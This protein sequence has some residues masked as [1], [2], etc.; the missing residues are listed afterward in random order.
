[1]S[2]SKQ[3]PLPQGGSLTDMAVSGTTV[4]EDAAKP[5]NLPS[6]AQPGQGDDNVNQGM[7][8][9]DLA[10]AAD[11]AGDIARVSFRAFLLL[12]TSFSG[13]ILLLCSFFFL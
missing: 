1:M 6:V 10:D 4:P 11:N 3:D 13:P 8:A 5:R 7:G 9:T 2:S 12:T